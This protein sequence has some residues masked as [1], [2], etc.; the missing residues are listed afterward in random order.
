MAR[1]GVEA[2]VAR[3]LLEQSGA[4]YR[5]SSLGWRFVND[6]QALFLP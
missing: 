2:A 6:I 3:G 5:P 1:V 4:K